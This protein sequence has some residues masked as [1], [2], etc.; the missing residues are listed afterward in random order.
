[1]NYFM[2]MVKHKLCGIMHVNVVSHLQC[3]NI[4]KIINSIIY[5]FRLNF[6]FFWGGGANFNFPENKYILVH[7]LL[8]NI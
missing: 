1:M 5:M 4:S 6:F 3:I 8:F 7:W 2:S